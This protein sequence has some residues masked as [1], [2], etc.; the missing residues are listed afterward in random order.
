MVSD[1]S[2]LHLSSFYTDY[3]NHLLVGALLASHW[4]ITLMGDFNIHIINPT[5]PLTSVFNFNL[6]CLDFNQFVILR[7]HHIHDLVIGIK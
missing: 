5:N 4:A 6:G 1:H 2:Y 7:T 3:S